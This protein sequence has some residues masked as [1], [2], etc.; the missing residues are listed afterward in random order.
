MV[1]VVVVVVVVVCVCVCVWGGGGGGG[2]GGLNWATE[3]EDS[4]KEN[5]H[6]LSSGCVHGMLKTFFPVHLVKY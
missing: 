2:G 3:L 6:C 4:R 1:V 5:P